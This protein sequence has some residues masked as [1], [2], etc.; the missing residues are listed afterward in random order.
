[1]G[2]LEFDFRKAN[3]QIRE[4]EE[5]ASWIERMADGEY[6][7]TMQQVSMAW[8]G[9]G[10]DAYMRK[11]ANLHGKLEDTA[12]EMRRTAATFRTVAA[13]V[14]AAEERA[15]AIAGKRN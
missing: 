13:N 8:K 7:D 1:M 9:A 12:R 6:N 2:M 14:R 3:A 4:L 15:M 5:L 11:A 10:A